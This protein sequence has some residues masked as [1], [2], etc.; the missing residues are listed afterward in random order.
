MLRVLYR[1]LMIDR[2][3]T[4]LSVLAVAVAIVLVVVLE[5]FQVGMWHQIRAY[6]EH[7]PVQLI[8]TRVGVE[9]TS[10]SRSVLPPGVV[11]QVGAVPGVGAVHPLVSMPM[12]YTRGDKKTTATIVGSHGVGGPWRL[13]KG[14][15]LTAPGEVVVD[16]A[17]ARSNGLA[18]GDRVE[19]FGREFQIVGLSTETAS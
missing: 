13:K 18:V 15:H 9:G 4:L 7:L 19:L 3:R 11:D 10:F 1:S 17:L 5:G 16:Y 12:I 14:R 2:G 8:A 6:R